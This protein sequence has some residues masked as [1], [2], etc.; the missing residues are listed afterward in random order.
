[1][2]LPLV[3][4]TGVAAH[5]GCVLAKQREDDVVLV[6]RVLAVH[7][8][9]GVQLRPQALSEK[10]IRTRVLARITWRARVTSAARRFSSSFSRERSPPVLV[11]SATSSRSAKCVCLKNVMGFHLS[12]GRKTPRR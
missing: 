4:V 10:G 9:E 6:A 1:V 7:H 5:A 2:A 12:T 3:V 8:E 11:T